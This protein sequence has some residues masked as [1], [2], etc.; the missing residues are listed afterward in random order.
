[1]KILMLGWE[2]PPH[3][4]GGL[5]VACE[6]LC[7]HLARK[8]IDLEFILPY[9]AEHD[10]PFK[11]TAAIPQS[12]KSVQLAG[13]AYDSQTY[14][15]TDGSNLGPADLFTQQGRY[16]L[17][18]DQLADTREIDII[19]AHDWLTFR[20]ALRLKMR[21]GKP[22][23]LH[24]HSIESDRAAGGH[25]NPL[26]HDIEEMALNLADKVIAVSEHTR[27][28]IH[29]HYGV[30]LENIE[31]VHNSINPSAGIDLDD[32]LLYTYLQQLRGQ[33]YRVVTNIGR[34]TIQKGL[35][36]LLHAFRMVVDK[37]PKT[38]LLLVGA[39]EQ[40]QELVTLSAEL[41]I[42]R[43]VLFAGFQR[44]QAWRDAF[45]VADLFVMPSVSEP[46]GLTPLEAASFGTPSLIS[47]QSGVSEI[48]S[49][50]LKVDYWD[51]HEMANQMTAA[52]RSGA[53]RSDL[54]E[55][56]QR[57]VGRMSWQ[58]AADKVYDL[59]RHH[60]EKQAVAA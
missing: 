1:M 18:V 47:K 4:S 3:N 8:D 2:L 6:Q 7:K 12:V 57:E 9:A 49:G 36:N 19:H 11:V 32:A 27:K 28:A 53:L 39:G 38:M 51:I 42:G 34:L 16:E 13:L 21:T 26:V 29:K 52:V 48:L 31:V 40:Y 46:F 50:A 23:I 20:A 58:K 5:G 59:Y 22:L 10:Q 43:N 17:A 24:V 55:T 44:G 15:Y 33:G 41:G 37:E 54:L 56:A 14:H 45:R 25:G 35:T 30:P 60:H